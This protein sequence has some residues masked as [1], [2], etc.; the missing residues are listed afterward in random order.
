MESTRLVAPTSPV[1]IKGL[2]PP[3]FCGDYAGTFHIPSA[4][5]ETSR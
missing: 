3:L 2:R 4:N 1:F 5:V